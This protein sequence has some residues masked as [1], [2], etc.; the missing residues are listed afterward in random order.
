[1]AVPQ[2]QP[3]ARRNS[4]LGPFIYDVHMQG[5]GVRLRWTH[6]DGGR[7]SSNMWTFTQKWCIFSQNFVFGR[8]KK[9]KFVG[10]I[11]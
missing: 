10:D 9:L 1:M 7:G 8:N 4:R 2:I 5:R 6:V 3:H 11:N